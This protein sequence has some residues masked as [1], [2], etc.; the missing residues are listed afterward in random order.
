MKVLPID[1]FLSSYEEKN[2]DLLILVNS[3]EKR[4]YAFANRLVQQT[5]KY[6]AISVAIIMYSDRGDRL[7]KQKCNVN[8]KV[9]EHCAKNISI[10]GNIYSIYL[11]PYEIFST[12]RV[13]RDLFSSIPKDSSVVVDISTMPK[14]HL[15]YFIDEAYNS[16]RVTTLR[17][18]YTRAR[19]GKY[20]ALSWGAEDPL[21]L[22]KFGNPNFSEPGK[23]CLLLFC[24]LEPERSYSIWR[25]FGQ[26]RC[27]MCF[28]D[29][30]EDDFDRP[31]L[32]AIRYNNF[33]E[34]ERPIIISAFQPEKVYSKILSIYNE[35]KQNKD[36]LFIAPL[37][38]K[39]EAYAIW[40]FFKDLGTEINASI[41]YCPPGRFNSSGYTVDEFGDIL[42][43][44][45][46][47]I[48]DSTPHSM[49]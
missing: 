8:Q 26:D 36:H 40:K 19:Y 39:W 3:F 20:D 13:F 14:M 34:R 15:I 18:V 7:V 21:I 10:N 12:I 29:S 9:L 30:G 38:T 33:D 42:F 24:G 47:I 5:Q 28:I 17:L 4:C 31:T 41:V 46:D 16:N 1:I 35:C 32:R 49:R 43:S 11:E 25:R 48:N 23:S 45:I 2:D 44:Q 6:K 27:I 22:P 37:T